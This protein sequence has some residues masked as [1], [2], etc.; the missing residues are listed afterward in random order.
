[1][2]PSQ[3]VARTPARSHDS[4]TLTPHTTTTTAQAISFALDYAWFLGTTALL[5]TLPV[6]VEIQRETTVLVLQKQREQEI[7]SVQEQARMSSGGVVDQ[8]RSL[9]SLMAA[10]AAAESS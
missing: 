1:M 8:I 7:L 4:P 6:V 2:D 5:L 9:G 3:R 10:G